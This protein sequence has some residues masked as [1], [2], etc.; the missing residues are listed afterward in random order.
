MEEIEIKGYNAEVYG[1]KA[2]DW[3]AHLVDLA[4]TELPEADKEYLESV[5][6]FWGIG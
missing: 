4:I 6:A 2:A 3:A 5:R 1:R